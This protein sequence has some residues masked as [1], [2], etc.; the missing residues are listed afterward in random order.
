MP[1]P[2]ENDVVMLWVEPPSEVRWYNRVAAVVY[3]LVG[4]RL[5]ALAIPAWDAQ[6]R[7]TRGEER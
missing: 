6:E 2:K 7:A 1:I 4:H 3:D 5:L